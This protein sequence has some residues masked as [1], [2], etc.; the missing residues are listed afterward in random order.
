LWA[1]GGDVPIY[2]PLAIKESKEYLFFPAG[3][4]SCVDGARLAL[5]QPMP[6]LLLNR[7]RV[8][9][10]LGFAHSDGAVKHFALSGEKRRRQSPWR[11]RLTRSIDHH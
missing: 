1:P 11:S 4:D 7:R 9:T 6:V 5:S 10:N 8:V 3:V 2:Q